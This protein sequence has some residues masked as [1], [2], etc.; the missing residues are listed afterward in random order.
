MG[1][2]TSVPIVK[3]S[4]LAERWQ[5]ALADL[6][7]LPH[8]V[9]YLTQRR[10]NP[11]IF[12]V[13]CGHSGTSILLAVLG[14]HS[15][16]Y[17]VPTETGLAYDTT[18]KRPVIN[19]RSRRLLR[20]FNKH[21]IRAGKMRWAEKTPSH[22]HSLPELMKLCPGCRILLIIRDGRDVACSIQDRTGNLQKGI[23][24]WVKENRLGEQY[25]Q[26]PQVHRL[27][28][29]DFIQNFDAT[30][31][32]VM[33]FLGEDFEERMR[34]HHEKPKLYYATTLEKPPDA[35][36][37][38][39]VQYRNWQIN[40]PIFDGRGKWQRLSPD[41][42]SLIKNEAGSMLIEYGYAPDADW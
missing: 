17:A 31:S 28:Y 21:A 37:D 1:D 10:G 41:E 32:G 36:G 16:I 26:H 18:N 3:K 39:H 12:V 27:K 24:R 19:K 8:A 29:E 6:R 15:R 13:G 2:V 40:Q 25:W 33:Q 5:G 22:I 7:N 14:A 23:Q 9:S 38:N 20:R 35:F 42:K 4:R 11:P 30:M 34:Q